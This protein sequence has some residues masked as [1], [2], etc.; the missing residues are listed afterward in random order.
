MIG[1]CAVIALE[2]LLGFSLLVTPLCYAV[3][4]EDEKAIPRTMA[5]SFVLIVLFVGVKV[6]G[7]ALP[8]FNIFSTGVLVVGG[9]VYFVSLL[10][11]S[12]KWYQAHTDIYVWHQILAIGS[13]IAA[14]FV[15]SV[16]DIS[17][18]RNMAGTFLALYLME[19]YIEIPNITHHWAL[20]SLGLG[21]ILYTFS[22]II[23]MYPQYFLFF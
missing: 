1:F 15:G 10:I 18:I 11:I 6:A 23:R 17:F 4:Y 19:K 14:L 12:S 9:F 7:V 8:Y 2:S 22:M 21:L 3:G 16:W 5:S 20:G 13:L